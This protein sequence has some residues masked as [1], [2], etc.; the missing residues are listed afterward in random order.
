MQELKRQK[1]KILDTIMEKETYKVAKELIE[2]YDPAMLKDRIATDLNQSVYL[3]QSKNDSILRQ[4]F[5]PMQPPMNPGMMSQQRM[6]INQTP[7]NTVNKP[8]AIMDSSL[9]GLQTPKLPSTQ[10]PQPKSAVAHLPPHFNPAVQMPTP[11]QRRPNLVRP[12]CAQ[13]R[14]I[15]E[16]FVDYL[17][18]DGPNN[19]YALICKFCH[20]HNGMALKDEFD[21]LNFRCCFCNNFNP[22]RKQKPIAPTLVS[23]ENAFENQAKDSLS[24]DTLDEN[25]KKFKIEDED[26]SASSISKNQ[27]MLEPQIEEIENK[28]N[29]TRL[30]AEKLIE[31]EMQVDEKSNEENA[32]ELSKNL[33]NLVIESKQLNQ[34]LDD[35]K[36]TDAN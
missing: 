12:V 9:V 33:D 13:D 15:V 1:R 6:M 34:E 21:Y 3:N 27:S 17:V 14:S 2:K 10:M 32:E 8:K 24:E 35:L 22:A 18:S 19:R 11:M 20:S 28:L 36:L 7:F 31:D 5:T 16:K 25:L 4:R 23:Y 29:G 30:G 26:D